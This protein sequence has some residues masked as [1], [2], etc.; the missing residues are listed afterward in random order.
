MRILIRNKLHELNPTKNW[1]CFT[2]H[3][4]MFC[5]SGLTK[6]QVIRLR[7]EFHVYMTEDGR[8]SIAGINEHNVDYIAECINMVVK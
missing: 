7:E 5:Y 6:D 8:V 3:R 2:E 1:S 4:G